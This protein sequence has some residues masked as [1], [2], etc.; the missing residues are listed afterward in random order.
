M[1]HK[2]PLAVQWLFISCKD[3]MK[4]LL[5]FRKPIILVADALVIPALFFCEWLSDQMLA[6]TSTCAWTLLGA[7]CITCGGTHFVN[8][9]LNGQF[10]EAFN[11]NQYLFLLA[12]FFAVSFVLLNLYWLF[13][14]R[15]AK[16]ALKKMYNIPVL[17]IACVG[18]LAFLVLR[19]IPLWIHL[20]HMFRYLFF[21]VLEKL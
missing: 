16:A 17:I 5:Q 14:L 7:K 10:V 11:H 13:D 18:V 12:I 9:L 8:T 1:I 15:F 4:K 2:K 19:N 21:L 20:F 3:D 6:T